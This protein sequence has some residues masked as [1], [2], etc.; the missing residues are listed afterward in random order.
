MGKWWSNFLGPVVLEPSVEIDTS[1]L[2][3]N[4]STIV[5]F[6]PSG[7]PEPLLALPPA[8]DGVLYWPMAVEVKAPEWPDGY[9]VGE[10]SH[11]KVYLKNAPGMIVW[12][13]GEPYPQVVSTWT[14]TSEYAKVGKALGFTPPEIQVL[15]EC[16]DAGLPFS[17]IADLIESHPP[18][19]SSNLTARRLDEAGEFIGKCREAMNVHLL[20][21]KLEADIQAAKFSAFVVMT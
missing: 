13:D 8:K 10:G 2:E 14:E 9:F 1:W 12:Y 15:V 5:G 19:Y 4:F 6:D 16:N 7:A 21:R 18:V 20:R 3:A 17:E 11:A